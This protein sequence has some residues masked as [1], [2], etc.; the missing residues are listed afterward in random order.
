MYPFKLLRPATLEETREARAGEPEAMYLSGGMT[1]IPSLKAHLATPPMLIDLHGIDQ[2]NGIA[3]RDGVLRVGALTTLAAMANASIVSG[4]IPELARMAGLVADRH[5]RNRGTIGGSIANNDPSADYP[6]AVLALG[7]T[8][9]TDQRR[10]PADNFFRGLFETDL[11]PGEILVALEF[12]V[13]TAAAYAKYAHPASGYAVAGVFVARVED[14]WRVALTGSGEDGVIRLPELEARLDAGDRGTDG[15]DLAE[16]PVLEDAAF[17]VDFRRHMILRLYRAALARL[18]TN[19][20][21][22]RRGWIGG[23]SRAPCR[24]GRRDDTRSARASNAP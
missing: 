15:I 4:A 1:L 11:E 5:V 10:I 2:M 6:A 3:L 24:A 22:S 13:P 14:G 9:V 17:P 16:L 20:G 21:F 18:Q 8:I 12:P 7:T 23:R 19:A